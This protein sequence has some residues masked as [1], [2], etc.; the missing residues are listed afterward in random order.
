MHDLLRAYAGE[1][2]AGTDA[3]PLR[4]AA[5]RRL[6][7]YYLHTAH[8]ANE[9]LD[10]FRED[11]IELEPPVPG[12]SAD[13]LR[14]HQ[15]ALRWFEDEHPTLRAAARQAAESGFTGHAWRMVGILTQFLDRHGDWHESA[16]LQEIAL[17]A[18]QQ[19]G[20]V[21]AQAVSHVGMAS[22]LGRVE[23]FE[24]ADVHYKQ[25]LKL[26]EQV[27]DQLGMAHA[28]RSR[29]WVM[30]RQHRFDEGL[31]HAEQALDLFRAAG[32]QTG[33]ARALNAVGWFHAR[34]GDHEESLRFCRLAL[35]L[36]QRMGAT[37]SQA[38]TLDSIGR[39]CYQLGRHDE[40]AVHLQA[41]CAL[42]REFSDRYNEADEL[43]V[44][45]D[46][47]L[48]AGD[49]GGARTVWRDALRIF[50][51]LGHAD[52]DLLRVKLNS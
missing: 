5:L 17:D 50:D 40:A 4:R 8:R 39:A 29:T 11:P 48:D 35:D 51:E 7:D 27:G 33:E 3:E 46:V 52:A 45:G 13:Q 26:Y 31:H 19:L 44:L 18:A 42:Y 38:E 2:V 6:L 47:R 37:L 14:D 25:A 34:L 9:L 10:R 43:V 30:D 28:L 21:R 1:L 23:R 20:D 36:Q 32:H 16:A 49:V 24:E 41:A 15:E 12:V 22:A